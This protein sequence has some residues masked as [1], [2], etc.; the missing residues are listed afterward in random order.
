MSQNVTQINVVS[1]GVFDGSS[2][3]L[4]HVRN[5][6]VDNT[7][8][9]MIPGFNE[10]A[11]SMR[12]REKP[13]GVGPTIVYLQR[14]AG[15]DGMPVEGLTTQTLADQ[16]LEV[17]QMIAA[18]FRV[19]GGPLR[20]AVLHGHSMGSV[21]ALRVLSMV[22]REHPNIIW[23]VITEAPPPWERAP[24]WF[25]N[26]SF[27]NNGG[28]AALKDAMSALTTNRFT[29][30][31]G[32]IANSE[33]LFRLYAGGLPDRGRFE[34]SYP[35]AV[36]DAPFA[37]ME[38]AFKSGLGDEEIVRSALHETQAAHPQ[39]GMPVWQI[40][41]FVEDRIFN[42]RRIIGGVRRE[43]SSLD[44]HATDRSVEHIADCGSERGP[45][46]HLHCIPDLPHVPGWGDDQGFY[47]R[48]VAECYRRL[49]F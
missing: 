49:M 14:R 22:R 33:T 38:L 28:W 4:V 9:F 11:L 19:Q 20:Y 3:R 35:L 34:Q 17:A 44:V 46:A 5:G 26:K 42:W 8:V 16:V 6:L 41:C 23:H 36:P 18:Y 30:R 43:V 31:R 2:R 47:H 24:L 7:V 29:R 15:E 12:D 37:F 21:I 39:Q 40:I 27:W 13:I 25:S 45:I 48:A 10:P 1:L 32:M